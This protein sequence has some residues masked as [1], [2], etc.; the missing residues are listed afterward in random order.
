MV[1][2]FQDRTA[3]GRLLAKK[4]SH[5]A[6]RK[7]VL[8]LGMA[9]GGVP[10]AFEVATLLR[11]PLDVFIVRKLGVPGREELAMGAIASGGIRVLNDA[12]IRSTRISVEVI[13]AITE[14]ER[15]ELVRRELAYR[16][17]RCAP[18][19]R[20]K[21]VILVDDGIATGST[22][23]AA[24]AALKEQ[25][26]ARIVVAAPAAPLVCCD[27]LQQKVDEFVVIARPD[28]FYS[29]G[30]A[31]EIFSQTSDQEVQHLLRNTRVLSPK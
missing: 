15:I 8:I 1:R 12:V 7:D 13:D 28:P 24:V 29:V 17:I 11:A 14:R 2:R 26:P 9:R 18:M 3:A 21:T 23:L 16:G 31:Y 4:L 30:E 19:V 22:M 6:D 27:E 20:E 10:V 25:E 5:Y